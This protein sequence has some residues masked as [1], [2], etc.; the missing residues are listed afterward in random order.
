MNLSNRR[1]SLSVNSFKRALIL[2]FCFILWLSVK[3][4]STWP[5]FSLSS[6]CF[7]GSAYGT[8]TTSSIAFDGTNFLVVWEDERTNTERDIFG[9]QVSTQGQILDPIGIPI[10][11]A[12]SWQ[13][14]V[15]VAAGDLNYLVVWMDYKNGNYDIYGARIDFAGNVLDP[16]GFI[17]S[18]GPW[19]EA[20]PEV[21]WDGVN[22]FVVWSDDR[23]GISY[24]VYGAR[25]APSGELLDSRGI[26]ISFEPV[27][28]LTPAISF[29]GSTY[30]VAW[31]HASG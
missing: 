29:N 17:I 28:E 27:M 22:F 2:S 12:P 16:N 10:C 1:K 6:D 13:T 5:E 7:L 8:Q 14:D 11:T 25:I 9:T 19:W 3:A 23:N 26:Q 31:E 24:D 20:Y 30:L 4:S 15:A 18:A 21:S